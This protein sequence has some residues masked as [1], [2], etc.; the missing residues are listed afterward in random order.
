MFH[1]TLHTEGCLNTPSRQTPRFH[2]Y[3]IHLIGWLI[4]KA[5]H[6]ENKSE[7]AEETKK[8][9]VVFTEQ[10]TVKKIKFL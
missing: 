2:V 5:K 9:E 3:S 1:S 10:N 4:I 6:A 8:M 7:R